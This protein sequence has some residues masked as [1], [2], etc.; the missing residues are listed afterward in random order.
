LGMQG[1]NLPLESRQ[2]LF[3][4]RSKIGHLRRGDS[5]GGGGLRMIRIR[6]SVGNL[7]AEPVRAARLAP[8]GLARQ[9]ADVRT[10]VALRQS[11]ENRLDLRYITEG[12]HA[13]R[14]AAQFARRLGAAQ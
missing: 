5:A 13:A 2:A 8:S 14:A 1:L 12:S 4:A 9:R 10:C 6:V 7:A 11:L 3:L